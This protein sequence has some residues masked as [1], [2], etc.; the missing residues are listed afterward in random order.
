MQRLLAFALLGSATA[1]FCDNIPL[2]DETL[3][4][5]EFVVQNNPY[6]VVNGITTADFY[7]HTYSAPIVK[8]VSNVESGTVSF[9]QLRT[10]LPVDQSG[11]AAVLQ[12]A[13]DAFDSFGAYDGETPWFYTVNGVE[14][15]N[16]VEWVKLGDCP[17][18]QSC[19]LSDI[20]DGLLK[21]EIVKPERSGA[22][23]Q[24]GLCN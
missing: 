19:D 12:S 21:D 2:W 17:E 9:Y 10:Q 5:A 3:T 8:D 1:N 7:L 20:S 22:Y 23:Q 24:A 4:F 16:D 18:P 13:S 11:A 15:P 6:A 14:Y